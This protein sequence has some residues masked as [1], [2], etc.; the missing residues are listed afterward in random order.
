MPDGRASATV[1]PPP[2]R[3][4][5]PHT[6]RHL[7]R[8]LLSLA[9]PL[10]LA[11]GLACLPAQ[12]WKI[13]PVVTATDEALIRRG[14][15]TLATMTNL[16]GWGGRMLGEPLHE[17]IV[18]RALG[19]GLDLPRDCWQQ[20]NV[21]W[22]GHEPLFAG[23]QWNDNP[24]FQ[25]DR[26]GFRFHDGRAAPRPCLGQ[27]I[28]LPRLPECWYLAM[29]DAEAIALDT[30]PGAPRIG[31]RH[32]LLYRSH[33]GDLQFLHAM[34]PAGMPASETVRRIMVWSEF[35]W[36]L[37][38]GEFDD[39]LP[40]EAVPVAGLR[41]LLGLQ[42]RSTYLL[43]VLGDE[44]FRAH[45]LIDWFVLGTL[46]HIVQDSFS[47]AHAERGLAGGACPNAPFPQ[48]GP[49]E[50]F[51]A[52]ELQD[53]DSHKKSD[54]RDAFHRHDLTVNNN[55]IQVTRNLLQLYR[56]RAPWARV[57]PYLQCVFALA[58]GADDRPA[59]AGA[60]YGR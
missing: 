15:W 32:P 42:G 16:G 6:M 10:L 59:E 39:Q 14:S 12:A 50:R 52:Y 35:A 34:A 23:L 7:A 8:H 19:C 36:R 47:E 21:Q 55:A 4:C 49:I 26:A 24:P 41:E 56:E 40:I 2:P 57:Q 46:L 37:A 44:T 60:G 58:P 29:R 38:Q 48:P 3:P 54:A 33:F 9:R 28:R 53:A 27:T 31:P 43:F 5:A 18:L 1:R 45:P 17:A 51:H 11:A 25:F 20:R 13:E 30:R 22:P